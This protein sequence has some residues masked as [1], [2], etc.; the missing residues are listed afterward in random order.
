MSD[1]SPPTSAPLEPPITPL[2]LSAYTL[3]S[4]LG[5]G[6]PAHLDALQQGNSGLRQCD[7]PGAIGLPAWIGRVDG[8][9]QYQLRQDL[10]RYDCRNNRLAAMGLTQDGFEQIISAAAQRYGADRIGVFI[11]TSTSGIEEAEQAYLEADGKGEL[12]DF[13]YAYTHNNFSLVDYVQRHCGLRGPACSIATACSSS[14]KVFAQAQ[15]YIQAGY[16][17]AALVGGVD[18]LCLTTLYGFNSLQLV[19]PQPCRPFDARRNGISIG[20]AAGFALLEKQPLQQSKAEP[21]PCLLGFGESS[22]AYHISRPHPEGLGAQLAMRQALHKAGLDAQQIDYLHLHG[23]GTV[24]NDL[25][26]D[27]AICQVFG[28]HTLCSSSKGWTGHTLGA[29]GIV[30]AVITALALQ[31]QFAPASL[32]LAQQDP[33]IH[34]RVLAENTP[35]PMRYAISNS[36]GFGGTNCS[37]LLGYV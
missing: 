17:D 5:R 24:A 15:R 11:G 7:F 27:L 18:S 30:G 26:E 25:T 8:L 14:A 10:L 3:T 4:A 19:A 2:R 22:D 36:F 12:K 37:L 31:H 13:R 35:H 33:Q 16:C 28:E 23:T 29:A 20:E 34:S 6:W 1:S 21:V 9:E 32:N